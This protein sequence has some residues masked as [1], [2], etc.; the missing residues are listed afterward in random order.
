MTSSGFPPPRPDP[1]VQAR[2]RRGGGRR[3][4]GALTGTLSEQFQ[5]VRTR[6][7]SATGAARKWR[8]VFRDHDV[9]KHIGRHRHRC[10]MK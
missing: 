9:T 4:N 8:V 6:C 2:S 10:L 7:G 3:V 1:R 5:P